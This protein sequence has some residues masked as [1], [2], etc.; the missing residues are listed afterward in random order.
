MFRKAKICVL[1][2]SVALFAVWG[3]QIECATTGNVTA[4]TEKIEKT[5]GGFPQ[6]EVLKFEE[7]NKPIEFDDNIGSFIREMHS[8]AP[9]TQGA[10]DAA[11]AGGGAAGTTAKPKKSSAPKSFAPSYSIITGMSLIAVLFKNIF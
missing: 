3:Q 1:V 9:S 6:E 2:V 5:V 10:T 11:A 7:E 4:V 8:D